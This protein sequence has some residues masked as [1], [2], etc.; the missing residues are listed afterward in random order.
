MAAP[1]STRA[2]GNQKTVWV[3]TIADTTAPTVAE[4]TAAGAKD[5]SCWFTADGWN[6]SLDESVIN[7]ARLCDTATFQRKGRNQRSLVVKYIENPLAADQATNNVGF[8]T[9]AP[10]SI[11]FFVVRRGAAY[12][13]ALA[14]TQL[15]QVWPVEMGE[16]DPLPPEENG[17]FNIQ[18]KAFVMNLVRL[19]VPIAA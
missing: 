10:N 1:N 2:D 11:G 5:L 7:D 18:Q 14:A 17:V 19:S 3:P 4:V 9:L 6:P 13:G 8:V 12:S 15:V 16:F